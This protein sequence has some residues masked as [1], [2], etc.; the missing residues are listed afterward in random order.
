MSNLENLA[1]RHGREGSLQK[2]VK[3]YTNAE[4]KSPLQAALAEKDNQ[5]DAVLTQQSCFP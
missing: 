3:L 5:R 1:H 2:G 4:C